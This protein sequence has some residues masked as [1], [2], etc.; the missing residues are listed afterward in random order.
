M[1]NSDEQNVAKPEVKEERYA[2][3]LTAE[4]VITKHSI[5][6]EDGQSRL[7]YTVTTG[8][9]PINDVLGQAEAGIFFMAYTVQSEAP[10]PLM[11]SFNGG[12]GS[13]SVWLHLGAVGP[14]RVLMKPDGALPPPPFRLTDNPLTWLQEVDLVFID[15]VGTGYSRPVKKDGGEKFWGLKG[16][17]ES[18]AEFIR[19]YLTRYERWSSPLF[20]VGE[21]YGTTRAA[22][23]SRVLL[24][25]GIALNGI[26]LVSSILNFQTLN[27]AK[28]NDLP[29]Q[30]FL[31]TYTATAWYHKKLKLKEPTSLR[32]VLDEAERYVEN[33]YA[34]ALS[35]GTSIPA[36]ERTKAC[37]RISELTGLS[38]TFVDHS[39]LRI[40]IH[41]FCKELLRTERRTVG[42]LDSRFKGIEELAIG[43]EPSHDPSLSAIRGP[44][45]AMLN[46]YIRRELGYKTDLPYYILGGIEKLW[47]SWDWGSAGKGYPDTSEALRDAFSQNPFMQVFIASGFYDLAT[48]YFATEYTIR[49]LS[50]DPSLQ[51]NI[52]TKYYES[53]H[54]MYIHEPSL[55][56]LRHDV[57][58]FL[59]KARGT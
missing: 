56:K 25:N 41:Q 44:Y 23:L 22:G 47:E 40:N 27:F 37:K 59:K 45:T 55:K 52:D 39:D 14:K 19:M 4:P 16:D 31:P 53:G 20:I 6:A 10:R 5:L 34:A 29:Y 57:F 43:S 11:F 51:K 9:M 1:G 33:E 28:G 48:P 35:Q 15:P 30:L 2:I 58:K 42:R 8:M 54:M 26:I 12:P 21:S 50:L 7:E 17:L 3:D 13:S 46:D 18:V 49:H 24:E 36:K 32:A 38:E